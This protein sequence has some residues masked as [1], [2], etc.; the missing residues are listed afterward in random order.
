MAGRC[1]PTRMASSLPRLGLTALT[2]VLGAC[3]ALVSPD[4]SR[5]G[6]GQDA[7]PSMDAPAERPDARIDPA[8]DAPLP[9]ENDAFVPVE[10]PDAFVMPGCDPPCGGGTSCVDGMC[11][12]P[13]D[14]CCPGCAMD[15][16]CV[17]GTCESCG[18]EGEVCCGGVR[19]AGAT[20]CE[21]FRCVSCGSAGERCCE[22]A[23]FEGLTCSPE[24][25]CESDC[26]FS[27]QACCEGGVCF[28]GSCDG[29]GP[30]GG[31]TC[32]GCGDRGE[33]C[34]EGRRCNDAALV[35]GGLGQCEEC[36]GFTQACC[37][38]GLCDGDRRCTGGRCI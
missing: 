16:E 19:C 20:T 32:Q 27:G 17:G 28:E 37:A 8:Q 29:G 26:G 36:G 5:L 22:G 12:C 34:C 25:V 23:C 1:Y 33:R 9:V 6:G 7:G 10:D 24:D 14:A 18:R 15:Q 3:S 38:G 21:S 13:L 31:P 11:V 35:C 2:L 30:F 4:P